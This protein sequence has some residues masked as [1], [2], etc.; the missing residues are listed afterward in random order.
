MCLK[1]L[2]GLCAVSYYDLGLIW[3]EV[4]TTLL[5]DL[6]CIFGSGKIRVPFEKDQAFAKKFLVVCTSFPSFPKPLFSN[7]IGGF[8]F[9]KG[10]KSMLEI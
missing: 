6:G 3:N 4:L 8:H 10:G 5:K 2:K 1:A 7:F 9:N